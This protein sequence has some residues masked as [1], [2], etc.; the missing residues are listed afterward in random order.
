[1]S[2]AKN[3]QTIYESKKSHLKTRIRGGSISLLKEIT[4]KLLQCQATT[5]VC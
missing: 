4:E 1:M 3:Y 2:T 5:D